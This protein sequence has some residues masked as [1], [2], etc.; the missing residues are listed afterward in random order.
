MAKVN[1]A[2]LSRYQ[3]SQTL[4]FR[5]IEINNFEKVVFCMKVLLL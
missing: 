2:F 4:H 5:H 3:Y 1:E